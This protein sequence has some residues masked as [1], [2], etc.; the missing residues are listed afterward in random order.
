MEHVLCP[1]VITNLFVINIQE[2]EKR[3]CFEDEK[4]VCTVPSEIH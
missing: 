2:A 1:K 4:L 3:S